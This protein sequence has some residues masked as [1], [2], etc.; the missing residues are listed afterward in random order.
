MENFFGLAG[1]ICAGMAS[2]IVAGFGEHTYFVWC[3]FMQ[4][5]GSGLGFLEVQG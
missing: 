1:C 3:L 2:D 5:M 4:W